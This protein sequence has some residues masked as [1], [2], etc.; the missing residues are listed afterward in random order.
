NVL[1]GRPT[2]V[3]AF[4]DTASLDKFWSDYGES[5]TV[6]LPDGTTETMSRLGV[7]LQQL[8][9]VAGATFDYKSPG[10]FT[11]DTTALLQLLY[12]L[13]IEH[14]ELPE[15][16]LG[17]A[18]ASSKASTETQMPVFIKF[19]EMRRGEMARWLTEI[20]EVVLAYLSLMEP[21]VVAESPQIQWEELDQA[22][23]QLT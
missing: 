6:E 5:E 11:S 1:Q 15:F 2:P 3:L 20:A 23:G 7:D 22:D 19:I 18:V 13:I 9:T 10:S 12:Y 21:G 14:T 17:S 16:V 8:L 4:Q